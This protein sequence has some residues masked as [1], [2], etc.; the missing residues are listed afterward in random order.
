MYDK[1]FMD[2][3]DSYISY[4]NRLNDLKKRGF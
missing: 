2:I 3:T 4:Q 1:L